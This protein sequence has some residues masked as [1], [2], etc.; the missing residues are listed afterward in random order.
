MRGL[1]EDSLM[2]LETKPL[3]DSILGRLS[4]AKLRADAAILQIF[5]NLQVALEEPASKEI[6]GGNNHDNN[7]KYKFVL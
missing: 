7:S 5:T 4:Q 2:N 6:H 1:N 3:I